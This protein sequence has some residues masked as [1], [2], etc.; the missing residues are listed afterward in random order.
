[1]EKFCANCGKELPENANA[2]PNCGVFVENFEIKEVVQAESVDNNLKVKIP[3]NGL[4]TAGMVLGIIAAVWAF[5]QILS[6][7][8]IEFAINEM[9]GVYDDLLNPS[10]I[11]FWFSFGYTIF[12]VIPALIGLPLSIV[13][14]VKHKSGKNIAGVIL[15]A[16]ALLISIF[17]FVYIMSLA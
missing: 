7:G 3:G 11:L 5:M 1:M 4:S 8:S 9:L 17:M 16:V 14:L 12:S 6:V 10:F 2:C 15:N 13:G